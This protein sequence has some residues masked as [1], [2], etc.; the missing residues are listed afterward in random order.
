MANYPGSSYIPM[1]GNGSMAV[2]SQL[3][4]V[5]M[6]GQFFPSA[7][8]APYYRGNGQGPATIPLNYIAS[9]GGDMSANIAA[10]NPWSI[11]QSPLPILIVALVGGIIWLR[12]IHW[13]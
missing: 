13:R 10:N 7:A 8:Q 5:P 3:V 6:L 2:N 12:V 4:N 9:T 11:T 1:A